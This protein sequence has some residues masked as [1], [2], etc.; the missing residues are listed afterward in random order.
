[1]RLRAV[2]FNSTVVKAYAPT[3][4]EFFDQLQNVTDQTAKMGILVQGDWSA[5]VGKDALK[6]DK[7]F[8]DPFAMTKQMRG[9]SDSEGNSK[10]AYH[11]QHSSD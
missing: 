1:M 3:L 8:V 5:K 10:R 6:T 9:D 2:P 4:K 11:L 7:A